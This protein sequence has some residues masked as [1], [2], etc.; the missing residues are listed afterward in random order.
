MINILINLRGQKLCIGMD[1]NTGN[2]GTASCGQG[3]TPVLLQTQGSI[4]IY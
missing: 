2:L 3:G 4:I 1:E